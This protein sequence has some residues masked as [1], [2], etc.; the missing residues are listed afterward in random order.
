MNHKER[1]IVLLSTMLLLSLLVSIL[2]ATTNIMALYSR[3]IFSVEQSHQVS[4]HINEA[5]MWL[6]KQDKELNACISRDREENQLI[7]DVL[8]DKG[9]QCLFN[10]RH[11]NYIWFDLGLF[12]C[13]KVKKP[14]PVSLQNQ[15]GNKQKPNSPTY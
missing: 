14:F 3:M 8:Y 4:E 12:P 11:Y 15:Q 13:V 9:C 2:N 5:A 6:A 10:S 7:E 1:G